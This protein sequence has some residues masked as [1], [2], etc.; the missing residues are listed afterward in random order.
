MHYTVTATDL[1]AMIH[2]VYMVSFKASFDLKQ[3]KLELELVF[4]HYPKQTFV[5]VA[6]FALISKQRVS[7]KFKQTETTGQNSLSDD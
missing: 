2:R 1:Y 4:R 3:P 5:S 6:C 7:V